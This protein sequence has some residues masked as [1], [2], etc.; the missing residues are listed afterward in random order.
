MRKHWEISVPARLHRLQGDPG[1]RTGGAVATAA[2][3]ALSDVA[4][5]SCATGISM[6]LTCA[7]FIRAAQS[8]KLR[9]APCIQYGR[10]A[11]SGMVVKAG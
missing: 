8:N 5:L 6:C 11:L 1:W 9:N 10:G 2:S 3:L 4:I 7:A